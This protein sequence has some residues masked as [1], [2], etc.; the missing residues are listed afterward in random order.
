MATGISSLEISE[1]NPVRR[2]TALYDYEAQNE[3]EL[4]LV[5]DQVYQQLDDRDSD[6]S[7]EDGWIR[8]KLGSSIGLVPHNYV[9]NTVLDK[10]VTAIFDYQATCPDELSIGKG[11]KILVLSTTADEGWWKGSLNGNTG[12]FP[13]NYVK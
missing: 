13:V 11:D 10:Y 4:N 8:V 2:V 9:T 1:A 12:L 5:K 7:M 3:D 6:C